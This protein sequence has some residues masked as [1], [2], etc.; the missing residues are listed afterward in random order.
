MTKIKL[1]FK[2]HCKKIITCFLVVVSLVVFSISSLAAEYVYSKVAD[3]ENLYMRVQNRPA[4]DSGT[5]GFGVYPLGSSLDWIR[6]SFSSNEI[7]SMYH[8]DSNTQYFFHFQMSSITRCLEYS[9]GFFN[10][11]FDMLIE[12]PRDLGF[13]V[14]GALLEF[15]TVDNPE[16]SKYTVSIPY[17][18]ITITPKG[19]TSS[20]FGQ[21]TRS[22]VRYRIS[23]NIP[24]RPYITG[25]QLNL[26]N[27]YSTVEMGYM[28]LTFGNYITTYY[29]SVMD[30]PADVRPSVTPEDKDILQQEQEAHDK[31]DY[32]IDNN[33]Y[34]L[35]DILNPGN[36]D[37]SQQVGTIYPISV[38]L[39]NLTKHSKIA[40]ILQISLSIGMF[41]FITNLVSSVLRSSRGGKK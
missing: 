34:H 30:I 3:F 27:K 22:Y 25:F 15:A 2:K 12:D 37:A 17:D 39:N 28:R 33:E 32:V 9:T 1:F 23:V 40:T 8:T 26:K 35:N 19:I 5:V 38:L 13:Y 29:A 31:L 41:A 14:Y 18:N 6:D 20:I 10:V 21:G 4:G 36:E 24:V 16:L 11:Q 7:T